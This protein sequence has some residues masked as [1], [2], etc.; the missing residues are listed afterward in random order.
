MIYEFPDVSP[1]L[2]NWTAWGWLGGWA[3]LLLAVLVGSGAVFTARIASWKY[4]DDWWWPWPLAAAV[5]W[6]LSIWVLAA[7]LSELTRHST[8]SRVATMVCLLGALV[9]AAAF[10]PAIKAADAVH[11]EAYYRSEPRYLF[12]VGAIPSAAVVGTAFA[13]LFNEIRIRGELFH[14]FVLLSISVAFIGVLLWGFWKVVSF[15]NDRNNSRY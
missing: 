2:T 12:L 13:V 10:Y 7:A 5:L 15:V 11:E 4:G 14:A 6:G 8:T 1:H 3:M 9:S